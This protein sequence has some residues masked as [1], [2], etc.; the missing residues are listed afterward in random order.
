MTLPSGLCLVTGATGFV[1]SHVAR[2]YAE[3]G[4]ELRLLTRSS[5]NVDALE[6]LN[7]DVV[8]GD[9]RNGVV[10]QLEVLV[11]IHEPG[12]IDPFSSWMSGCRG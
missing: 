11:E 3:A 6:G 5:S 12:H 10:G 7:A 4:A 2:V 1:G 8:V 9:L